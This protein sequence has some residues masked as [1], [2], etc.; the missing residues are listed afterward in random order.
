MTARAERAPSGQRDAQSA[1]DTVK[2]TL[3]DRRLWILIGLLVVISAVAQAIG[4]AVI[5]LGIASITL[6]PMIWGLLAGGVVSG[7]PW[8]RFPLDLQEA[9]TVI[10]GVAV[11]VLAPGFRSR[12]ARTSR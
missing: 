10:M 1:L 7:Q 2:L 9:A 5:P 4:P 6:L 8:K 12:S 11:L 3:L